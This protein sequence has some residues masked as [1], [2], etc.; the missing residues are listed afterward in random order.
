MAI[1]VRSANQRAKATP[2]THVEAFHQGLSMDDS[3]QQ[4]T[5]FSQAIPL[6]CFN[7]HAMA[8]LAMY[9]FDR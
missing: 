7:Q 8:Q 5:V 2:Q 1:D 3:P 6:A 4:F 9:R